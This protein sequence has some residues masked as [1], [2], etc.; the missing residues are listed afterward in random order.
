LPFQICIRCF[1]Y[2]INLNQVILT[3]CIFLKF[4]A[5]CW[6]LCWFHFLSKW[7]Q[8]FL[9]AVLDCRNGPSH[10]YS[11][12]LRHTCFCLNINHIYWKSLPSDV[13]IH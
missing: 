4:R 12:G 2:C 11:F 10:H 6:L 9:G 5:R 8:I 3:S 1:Q 13:I 7:F